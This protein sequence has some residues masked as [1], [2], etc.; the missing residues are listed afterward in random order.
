MIHTKDVFKF[1]FCHNSTDN[2]D[3]NNDI[4]CIIIIMY[5]QYCISKYNI[6]YHSIM[7]Y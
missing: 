5:F 1:I 2:Y 4:P 6:N 7:L 3:L